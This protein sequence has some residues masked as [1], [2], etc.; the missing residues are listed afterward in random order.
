MVSVV[1]KI[2]ILENVNGDKSPIINGTLLKE[3]KVHSL[4]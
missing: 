4:A 3:D 1:N 2:T